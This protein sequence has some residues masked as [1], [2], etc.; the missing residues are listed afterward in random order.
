MIFRAEYFDGKDSNSKTCTLRCEENNTFSIEFE[1][2]QE[3]KT[4][5][6]VI[7]L[8][9]IA[10]NKTS[11]KLIIT[12]KS[13]GEYAYIS[14]EI[15]GNQEKILKYLY[16]T[17]TKKQKKPWYS[18]LF[19]AYYATVGIFLGLWIF[20]DSLVFL[21]PQRI[22]ARLEKTARNFH[23][24]KTEIIAND[25]KDP[26]LKKIKDAFVKIDPEL[27]G[28]E[29]ELVKNKE[30][31]AMAIPNKKIIIYSG[32]IHY[33]D[34][35]DELMGI[36]AHEMTH[37][38]LRHSIAG[39]IKLS[40]LR[41]IDRVILGN[42]LSSSG[43]MLYFLRFSQAREAEADA[44]A[45]KYLDELKL[46][47]QGIGNFFKKVTKPRSIESRFFNFISTHP[48]SPERQKL[49][50]DHKKTYKDPGFTKDDLAKLK[51]K[52]PP[53]EIDLST[54]LEEQRKTKRHIL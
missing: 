29:I 50:E 27:S 8:G 38:K 43:F 25:A 51:S 1:E 21:F 22:E 40:L 5:L 3:D 15:V 53:V 48:S 10:W 18:K 52:V 6:S 2:T 23:L 7:P 37:V 12:S 28:V 19:I 41:V 14:I 34:S 45:I 11:S 35:I 30:H 47:T 17:D 26:T 13:L 36:I 42:A 31:N 4:F 46:S 54:H 39:Y 32:L 9:G 44:G 16:V 49:F 33:V 24:S 20:M